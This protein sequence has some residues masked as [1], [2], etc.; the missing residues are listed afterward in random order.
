MIVVLRVQQLPR[1]KKAF[2]TVNHDGL[3]KL[4]KKFGCSE[5]VTHLERPVH[6]G[7]MAG[8]TNTSTVSEAFAG[9]NGVNQG[10]VL[11][12]HPLQSHVL[13]HADGRLPRIAYRTDGHLPSNRRMQAP[14]CVSTTSGHDLLFAEDCALTH[15]Q[16]I[17][18]SIPG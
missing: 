7:M 17:W 5:R 9:A 1:L 14:T 15:I 18:L 3:C 8:I 16:L 6:D 2:D 4:M 13:Y 10:C 11:A 12:P